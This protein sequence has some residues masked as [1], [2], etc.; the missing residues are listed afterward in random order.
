MGLTISR[1]AALPFDAQRLD[2]FLRDRVFTPLGMRNCFYRPDS[3][4][5]RLATVYSA[6]PD[7]GIART[8]DTGGMISQGAYLK[9]PRKS[10][11]GRALVY[12]AIVR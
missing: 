6:A 5:D 3:K 9:R 1:L 8:P 10:F 2:A 12:Q 4:A 7:G 11:F